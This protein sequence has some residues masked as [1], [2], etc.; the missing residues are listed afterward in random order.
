MGA[1]DSDFKYGG[2]RCPDLGPDLLGGSTI[3]HSL[4]VRYMCPNSA[5]EE[6]F[7]RIS[8]QGGPH[9]DREAIE[10]RIRRSVG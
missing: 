10:E 2:S 9:D 6:V 8:S 3:V 7:G 1:A 5:H 4:R